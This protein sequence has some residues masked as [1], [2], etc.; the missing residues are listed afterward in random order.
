MEVW[1]VMDCVSL[2]DMESVSVSSGLELVDFCDSLVGSLDS[3]SAG[4]SGLASGMV[5]ASSSSQSSLAA[6]PFMTMRWVR[7]LNISSGVSNDGFE[8]IELLCTLADGLVRLLAY[9][10]WDVGMG[11]LE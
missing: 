4:E 10:F 7:K 1:L 2:L 9:L 5:I 6:W 11:L 3:L 8:I